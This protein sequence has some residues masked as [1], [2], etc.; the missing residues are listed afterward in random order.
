MEERKEVL[1]YQKDVLI[2]LTFTVSL[3][4][5]VASVN[6]EVVATAKDTTASP[7]FWLLKNKNTGPILGRVHIYGST[8]HN[9]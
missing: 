2:F 5:L 6:P 1:F 8:M 7:I 9:G 3:T 4:K